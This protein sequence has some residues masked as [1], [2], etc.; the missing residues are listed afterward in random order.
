MPQKLVENAGVSAKQRGPSD[1]DRTGFC[2]WISSPGRP[3]LFLTLDPVTCYGAIAK[4]P[5]WGPVCV[6]DRKVFLSPGAFFSFHG[7]ESFSF[8]SCLSTYSALRNVWATSR[9]CRQPV[10]CQLPATTRCTHCG[11]RGLPSRFY[12]L[13]LFL[14]PSTTTTTAAA[15]IPS[16]TAAAA[17]RRSGRSVSRT[18]CATCRRRKV[19]DPVLFKRGSTLRTDNIQGPL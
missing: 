9:A 10:P 13:E 11:E 18:G 6:L 14:L 2:R 16:S 3:P 19:G 8:F 4:N 12:F 7:L 17:M 5:L 1:S 15:H